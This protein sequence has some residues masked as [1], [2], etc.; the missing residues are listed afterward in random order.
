MKLK[1]WDQ[2]KLK[3]DVNKE[4]ISLTFAR[5]IQMDRSW[6]IPSFKQAGKAVREIQRND[7]GASKWV[8]FLTSWRYKLSVIDMILVTVIYW[9]RMVANT[10]E[11]DL[12]LRTGM[13]CIEE[14]RTR[15][16][17]NKIKK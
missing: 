15:T 7:A 14:Y 9:L 10:K 8:E 4:S 16:E 2:K 5:L 17:K 11:M 3:M 13:Q 6:N 12:S 1:V